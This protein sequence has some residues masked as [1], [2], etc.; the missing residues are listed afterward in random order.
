MQL[1]SPLYTIGTLRA[2]LWQANALD[3]SGCAWICESEAGF[4]SSPPAR[5][6][7]TDKTSGDG[8]WT[9]NGWYSGRVITLQGTCVAPNQVAMLWAKMAIK[10]AV[11]PYKPLN[12]RVD[13]LHLSRQVQVRLNDQ[14]QIQDEGDVA[15]KWQIALFAGDPRLYSVDTLS[16]SCELPGEAAGGTGRAYPRSYPRLYPGGGPGADGEVVFDQ[17]GDYE[18][19]P[20]VITVT[21]PVINPV[22]QHAESGSQLAFSLT[23]D[24]GQVLTVD[25]GSASATLQGDPASGFLASGSA[26]FMLSEGVNQ[27]SF[28]GAPGTAPGGVP[29]SPRMTLTASSAWS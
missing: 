19:T 21:G 5:P 23:V 1:N 2:P 7:Q 11:K 15:F 6:A 12:L 17:V 26:W 29:G 20:A 8:T 3:D 16:V 24:Y 14:V 22:I 18:Q 25:L 10:K 27:V 13:E 28:R 9:G 4:S